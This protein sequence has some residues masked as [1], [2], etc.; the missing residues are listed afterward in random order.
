MKGSRSVSGADV[1]QG[2]WFESPIWV[3]KK[4]SRPGHPWLPLWVS[5]DGHTRSGSIQMERGSDEDLLSGLE[6]MIV[7]LGRKPNRI[8]VRDPTLARLLSDR[9]GTEIDVVPTERLEGVERFLDLFA[10]EAS[11]SDI[12]GALEVRG[13]TVE[14]MR[15]FAEAARAFYQAAPWRHLTNRDLIEIRAGA[16]PGL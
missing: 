7:E 10:K 4:D 2:G 11:S 5:L 9:L 12:P 6:E 16:P 3:T 14:A 1:W 13:V 8:E 15:R